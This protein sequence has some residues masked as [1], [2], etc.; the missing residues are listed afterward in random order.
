MDK[1]ENWADAQPVVDATEDKEDFEALI[2]EYSLDPYAVRSESERTE[3]MIPFPEGPLSVA[4]FDSPIE[5]KGLFAVANIAEGD[6][7][8]HGRIDNKR[9]PAG[10]Y[11][12]HSK[13]PN[14]APVNSVNGVDFVAL[15]DIAGNKGGFAGE[16]I[17][18][19]YR[20]AIN[21]ER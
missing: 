16:E 21:L 15:R 1:S 17:T 7:V 10:R 3:D 9:T 13:T 11:T 8:A 20:Q 5:G 2:E 19:D 14:S 4:V 18:I 12:N 6:L